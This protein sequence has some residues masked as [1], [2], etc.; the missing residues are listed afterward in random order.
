MIS[1]SDNYPSIYLSS[2]THTGNRH[3]ELCNLRQL[4][5]TLRVCYHRIFRVL[6]FRYLCN[7]H[8]RSLCSMNHRCLH[9][10]KQSSNK[11]SVF[12]M[13]FNF[14]ECN[15]TNIF[16][17][18]LVVFFSFFDLF[19]MLRRQRKTAAY[20]LHLMN[21]LISS[22]LQQKLKSKEIE[23]K[24]EI[25]VETCPQQLRETPPK[26]T[27]LRLEKCNKQ[28]QQDDAIGDTLLQITWVTPGAAQTQLSSLSTSRKGDGN[29]NAVCHLRVPLYSA[30]SISLSLFISTAGGGRHYPLVGGRRSPQNTC[31]VQA[32]LACYL[33]LLSRTRS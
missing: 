8:F 11:Q 16:A 7:A 5:H 25:F 32:S 15:T 2:G 13:T 6:L 30:Q 14:S 17:F 20:D 33:I 28:Q 12:R 4:V 21:H 23:M 24:M 3:T 22:V 1:R 31:A 18:F 19:R 9:S 27:D 10:A 29:D 26:A